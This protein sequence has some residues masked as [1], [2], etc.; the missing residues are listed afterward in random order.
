[1]K[2]RE[3]SFSDDN[4]RFLAGLAHARTGIVLA[5]QKKDM[6]YS[7]LA[8]RLR[9]LELADFGQYCD[10]LQSPAGTG[11]MTN[12]INALTTNLTSFFREKHH[13]DHLAGMLAQMQQSGARRLRIWSAGCSSGM[14][15]YSIAMTAR[16]TLPDIDRWDARVLATDIDSNML[17][18]GIAGEYPAADVQGVPAPM[19][20]QFSALPGDRIVMGEQLKKMIAFKHLNLLE[21]WPMKGPFDAIFCRN[22]VIY[23][24]KETKTRIFEKFARLLPAGGLLYIGHSENLN[25]ISD[26]FTPVGRTIYRRDA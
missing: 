4:F 7:R 24:D 13:F 11:E 15:P 18:A 21:S 2:E 9:A 20:K 8:R 22:V 14:E 3:F 19:R 5:E 12:L 6:V 17:S 23:F 1:M 26:A 16:T 10:M 25:G